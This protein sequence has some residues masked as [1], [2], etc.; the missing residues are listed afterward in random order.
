[1]DR[2]NTKILKDPF[3]PFLC[4]ISKRKLHRNPFY[5]GVSV[6]MMSFLRAG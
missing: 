2:Y 4:T 1:M 3:Q 6:S 5:F